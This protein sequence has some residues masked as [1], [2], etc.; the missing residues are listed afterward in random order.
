MILSNIL[1]KMSTPLNTI[2][3]FN[4]TKI[5]NHINNN[6]VYNIYGCDKD[7][8][9]IYKFSKKII[10]H[11]KEKDDKTNEDF[12]NIDNINEALYHISEGLKTGDNIN[13]D[14]K[15]IYSIKYKRHTG[16]YWNR[17]FCELMK[18]DFRKKYFKKDIKEKFQQSIIARSRKWYKFLRSHKLYG[19]GDV[20]NKLIIE[21]PEDESL[22]QEIDF[23]KVSVIQI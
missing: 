4:M 1:N 21:L 3:K 2:S 23:S 6:K 13:E 22:I 15:N 18:L 16:Y 20:F 8:E 17:E 10:D 14:M 11:I 19:C 12:K 9:K 7:Y 5:S